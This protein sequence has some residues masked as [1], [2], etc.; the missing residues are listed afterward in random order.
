MAW[1]IKD[2]WFDAGASRH[3]VIFHNPDILVHP[4]HWQGTNKPVPQE[5]H[6]IHEFKTDACLHCGV[7][8]AI[9]EGKPVDFEAV[10]KDVLERLNAHHSLVMQHREASPH[11]RLGNGPRK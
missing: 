4:P 3:Y 2:E 8:H 9:A 10:K 6:L 7:V 11:V 1:Q 5:H